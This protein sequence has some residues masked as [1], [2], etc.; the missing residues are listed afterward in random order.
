MLNLPAFY[1]TTFI[2]LE[3]TARQDRRYILQ[4]NNERR[5]DIFYKTCIRYEF[6]KNLNEV[7]SW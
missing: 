6:R 7:E 2:Q 5:D 4:F 3:G 1:S